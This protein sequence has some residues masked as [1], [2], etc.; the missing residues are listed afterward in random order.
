MKTPRTAVCEHSTSLD[1]FRKELH[2]N[3]SDSK[4]ESC[5]KSLVTGGIIQEE[6]QVQ[7]PS[8]KKATQKQ[9]IPKAHTQR[10]TLTC[11]YVLA[12]LNGSSHSASPGSPPA[13]PACAFWNMQRD[14]QHFVL[15]RGKKN[16]LLSSSLVF[17]KG[18]VYWKNNHSRLRLP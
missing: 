13:G 15:L 5:D 10:H 1:L 14:S 3:F 18:C 8:G 7:C 4:L 12:S 16:T 2:A 6:E 9:Q 17:Y 11:Q